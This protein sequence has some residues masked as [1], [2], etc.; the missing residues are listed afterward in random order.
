M[1]SNNLLSFA[2]GAINTVAYDQNFNW[3]STNSLS[4]IS[5]AGNV[6][7]FGWTGIRMENVGTGQL[8]Q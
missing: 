5:I 7:E 8:S 6:T 1:P 3:V 2:G 4:N